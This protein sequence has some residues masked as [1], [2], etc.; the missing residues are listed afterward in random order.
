MNRVGKKPLSNDLQD[1][2]PES[3]FMDLSAFNSEQVRDHIEDKEAHQKTLHAMLQ[4]AIK[5][6]Q[7]ERQKKI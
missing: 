6:K 5:Q 3:C 7:K 4:A 2:M 1:L